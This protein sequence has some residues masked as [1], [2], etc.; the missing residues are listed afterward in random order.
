MEVSSAS[1]ANTTVRPSHAPAT[2]GVKRARAKDGAEG[3]YK[4]VGGEKGRSGASI[5]EITDY[6]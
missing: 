1:R 6:L 3:V 4:F 2:G 5:R